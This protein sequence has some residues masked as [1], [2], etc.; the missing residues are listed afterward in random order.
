MA[1]R[2]LDTS[3]FDALCPKMPKSETLSHTVAGIR[4]D[5]LDG[6]PSKVPNDL[7]ISIL[8]LRD[9]D[10]LLHELLIDLCLH[11]HEISQ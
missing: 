9:I 6:H 11:D 5:L 10:G 4:R 2:P 7:Q 8:S 3:P 1:S